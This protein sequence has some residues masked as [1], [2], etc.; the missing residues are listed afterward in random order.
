MAIEDAVCIARLLPKTTSAS[1]VEGRLK[2]YEE[3]RYK[4]VEYVRDQTRKNGLDEDER[5]SGGM[6]CLRVLIS[7]SVKPSNCGSE[8]YATLQYCY[9]HDEWSNTEKTLEVR[10]ANG[11]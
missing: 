10:L 9:Q 5:S 8:L 4:R 1:E 7:R 11:Q 3:I 6:F 2:C